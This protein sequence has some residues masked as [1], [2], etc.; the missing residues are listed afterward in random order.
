[1]DN[2]GIGLAIGLLFLGI[3]MFA[4]VTNVASEKAR[5]AHD[6]QL[7]SVEDIKE[8]LVELEA[9]MLSHGGEVE[10]INI[11]NHQGTVTHNSTSEAL[12]QLRRSKTPIIQIFVEANSVPNSDVIINQVKFRFK[13]LARG[14]SPVLR[15]QG[16]G[17]RKPLIE[18]LYAV[19]ARFSVDSH[20]G[21]GGVEAGA[22][23][24]SSQISSE[25]NH[26]NKDGDKRGLKSRI[27]HTVTNQPMVVQIIGGTIATLLAALIVTLAGWF[28]SG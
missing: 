6:L 11:T 27:W 24:E 10:S 13:D 28:I 3:M 23:S 7:K 4:V 1:M 12:Q 2:E 20:Q 5:V 25:I 18:D 14:Q 15:I 17:A 9:V 22:A 16:Y 8:I 26:N 19:A 21:K